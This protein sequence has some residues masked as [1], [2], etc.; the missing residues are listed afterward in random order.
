MHRTPFDALVLASYTELWLIYIYF[1]QSSSFLICYYK[2]IPSWSKERSSFSLLL[3]HCK[4]LDTCQSYQTEVRGN[5]MEWW[6]QPRETCLSK[7]SWTFVLGLLTWNLYNLLC[8]LILD[9]ADALKIQNM[10]TSWSPFLSSLFCIC[11]LQ[12]INERLPVSIWT[13]AS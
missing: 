8:S 13:S 11:C 2:T 10:S 9:C 6:K 12:W 4:I 3:F 1:L 5:L 7:A